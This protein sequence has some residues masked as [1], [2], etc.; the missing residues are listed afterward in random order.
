VQQVRAQAPTALIVLAGYPALINDDASLDFCGDAQPLV[1]L[2]IQHW[3]LLVSHDECM[4]LNRVSDYME[5]VLQ[6]SDPAQHI[7]RVNVAGS[8]HGHA[9]SDWG[10]SDYL[11]TVTTPRIAGDS[12]EQSP[13]PPANIVGMGSFHPTSAGS[14]YG[15]AAKVSSVLAA[16]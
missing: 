14:Q 10:S 5:S 6:Q 2:L 3:N 12:G 8:F 4:M 7:L 13:D 1:C 11:N 15:Y 16:Q 9:I